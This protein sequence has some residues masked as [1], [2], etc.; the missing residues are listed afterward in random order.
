MH[1]CGHDIHMTTFIGM[2]RALAK[3]KDQWHGTVIFIGQPRKKRRRR[4][5]AAQGRPLHPLAEAGLRRSAFTTTRSSRP[6]TIGVTEGYTYANVDSVDMTV[7]GVGGH[8]AYP[9]RTKD[10]IVLAA[11]IINACRRSPGAKTIRSIRPWS[12]S[13]PFTAGRSTTSSRTK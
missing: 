6:A 5:R 4:A 10:P 13:A 11:E 12:R 3:L 8:G 2:A 1:A 7:R 9:H